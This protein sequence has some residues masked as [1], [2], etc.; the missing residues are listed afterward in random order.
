[1]DR[2][3]AREAK[4]HAKIEAADAHKAAAATKKA[5]TIS[6]KALKSYKNS[7]VIILKVRSTFLGSLGLEDKVEV[8]EV[9]D[10]GG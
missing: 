4:T 10:K 7:R 8:K 5:T 9:K 3:V 6:K 1:V 2:Q